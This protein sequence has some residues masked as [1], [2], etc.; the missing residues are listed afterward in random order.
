MA[1]FESLC[2][3]VSLFIWSCHARS[4]RQRIFVLHGASH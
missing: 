1:D 3:V 2:A 4:P